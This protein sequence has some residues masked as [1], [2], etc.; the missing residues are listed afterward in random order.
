MRSR[1]HGY[2]SIDL[3]AGCSEARARE[4][5][6]VDRLRA[7]KIAIL[8]KEV[9]HVETGSFRFDTFRNGHPLVYNPPS[10]LRIEFSRAGFMNGERI[11][12]TLSSGIVEGECDP[13]FAGVLQAFVENFEKRD[14]L[15]AS[16]CV[17]VEG[18][19]VVDLWGGKATP[20]GAPWKRDTVSIVFSATKGAS[21]LCAHMAADRGLLDFNAPVARYWPAFAQAGKEDALVPMMLDHSVGVP[22]VRA[23]LKYGAFYDYDHMVGL[24]ERE[25]AFWKPGT[26]NG[27]HGMTS[28]WTVGEMVHRSTGKR[29]G[30]FFRDEVAKP[31]GIDFWIGLPAEHE[32]RVAPVIYPP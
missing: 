24:L 19:T 5:A 18:R 26:R 17:S 31:L 12:L 20:N 15:G 29:L 13:K 27:Y 30:E 7:P 9:W 28:A 14:E 2:I 8:L 6:P 4:P 3:E 1:T 11:S 21:A 32:S 22:H 16:V 25:E 23:P 10:V